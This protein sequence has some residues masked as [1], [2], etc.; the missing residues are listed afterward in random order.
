MDMLRKFSRSFSHL[1][2][3]GPDARGPGAGSH[4]RPLAGSDF[5]ADILPNTVPASVTHSDS[6]YSS[7][8]WQAAESP[9]IPRSRS[10]QSTY[11]VDTVPARDPYLDS[12]EFPLEPDFPTMDDFYVPDGNAQYLVRPE[13]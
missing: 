3:T 4:S 8:A 13:R 6:G 9:H 11:D 12:G 5:L 10:Q 2:D 1:S 7:R